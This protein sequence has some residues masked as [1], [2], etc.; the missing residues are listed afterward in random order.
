MIDAQA[1][2]GEVVR[3]CLRRIVGVDRR[4]PVVSFPCVLGL[5]EVFAR[6]NAVRELGSYGVRAQLADISEEDDLDA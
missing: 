2:V 5:V 6:R 1:A 3:E 4:E